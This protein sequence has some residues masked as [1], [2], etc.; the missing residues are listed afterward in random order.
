[1]DG[2]PESYLRRR[3]TGARVGIALLNLLQPGLGL[4][5]LGHIRLAAFSLSISLLLPCMVWSYF[6]LG[7]TL[8]FS[9]WLAVI[10]AVLLVTIM[11]YIATIC[12]SWRMSEYVE[13]RSGWLW[14]W[15]GISLPLVGLF[16]ID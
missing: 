1:M 7:P 5:R 4:Q 6:A 11:L 3:R 8:T 9:T 15:F 14:R 13:A 2:L 10:G 16:L 12:A